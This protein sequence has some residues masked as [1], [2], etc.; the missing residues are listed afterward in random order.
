MEE[1][2]LRLNRG[3][4]T[5]CVIFILCI[6]VMDYPFVARLYN[7]WVQ[8]E[9]ALNYKSRTE[10]AR[11]DWEAQWEQAV[12]YNRRLASGTGDPEL[13]LLEDAGED[14]VMA[15][16]EI[17]KIRVSLPVYQGTSQ[18]V[19]QKGAGHL[20]GS[21]LP[22]GGSG[23]HTVISAHRGLPDCRMFTDLDQMKAG[24]VFFI[25]FLQEILAYEVTETEIVRPDQTES[26]AICEGEDLATLVT[27][28][29]YGI[30]THRMYVHG[31][32]IPYEDSLRDAA[33]REGKKGWWIQYW[34]IAATIALLG[35]MGILL[36]LLNKTEGRRET[37][38]K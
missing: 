2:K 20:E 27:C 3:T 19:L 8:G 31:R 29:P 37:D 22:T 10:N 13:L 23:T 18:A 33:F 24:D 30:N 17:P 1:K 6:A 26:L 14:D 9:V 38:M 15:L 36:A 5:Y 34:W 25:H 4:I 32:R 16:I 7:E 21:S 28:T 11:E 35:W 12:E